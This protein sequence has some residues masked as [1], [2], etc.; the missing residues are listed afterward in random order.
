[1]TD[2]L[3]IVAFHVLGR[4]GCSKDEAGYY[5]EDFI[6]ARMKRW[7]VLA[8]NCYTDCCHSSTY[9][10][11]DPSNILTGGKYLDSDPSVFE[12]RGYGVQVNCLCMD[13]S[14]TAFFLAPFSVFCI[15]PPLSFSRPCWADLP[16]TCILGGDILCCCIGHFTFHLLEIGRNFCCCLPLLVPFLFVDLYFEF[17]SWKNS[18]IFWVY[19]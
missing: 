3:L 5:D 4:F 14:L 18:E 1:M 7:S 12:D 19:Q 17:F 10:I 11:R 8:I 2:F 9:F 13:L 6:N 16:S 15:L